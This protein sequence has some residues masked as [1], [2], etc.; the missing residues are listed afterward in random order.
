MGFFSYQLKIHSNSFDNKN[1]TFKLENEQPF[2]TI[3]YSGNTFTKNHDKEL[4]DLLDLSYTFCNNNKTLKI[5]SS[6]ELFALSVR[7]S[8]IESLSK[9]NERD[10]YTQYVFNQELFGKREN[11]KLKSYLTTLRTKGAEEFSG[12]TKQGGQFI[13]DISLEKIL[14]HRLEGEKIAFSHL[15]IFHLKYGECVTINKNIIEHTYTKPNTTN[16]IL[17]KNTGKQASEKIQADTISTLLAESI[18]IIENEPNNKRKDLETDEVNLDTSSINLETSIIRIPKKKRIEVQVNKEAIEAFNAAMNL[19][20]QS[21][22]IKE[23]LKAIEFALT[24][25]RDLSEEQVGQLYYQQAYKQFDKETTNEERIRYLEK[26][27]L[28]KKHFALI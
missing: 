25:E 28:Y 17:V 11:R 6:L 3:Y 4:K 27:L 26:A 16:T 1:V 14:A 13:Y 2:S 10:R 19:I 18:K 7:F 8:G 15:N 24:H 5:T 21:G 9:D 23:K 12:I 20:E 22:N